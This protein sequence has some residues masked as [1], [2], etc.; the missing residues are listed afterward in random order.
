MQETF[1]ELLTY[2]VIYSF[3][4]WVLESVF[5]SIC[6]RK[7]INTG[8]LNGPF[9]PIYGVGAIIMIVFLKG[10]KENI[11]LLF[12]MA[13]FV[14]SVWEYVV[15]VFLEGVFHTK[16]WDYSEHKINLQGRVCL[17]NS[18]FWG[19]L[20]IV[21]I[22]YI[23]PFV[24][25]KLAF[26]NLVWLKVIIYAVFV[27]VLVDA[28]IS[29]VKI[30]NLKSTLEKI[31]ELNNQI[32]EKLEEIK[33]KSKEKGKVAFDEN[34]QQM[35]DKLNKERNRIIRKIYKRVSRLKKAFPTIDTKEITEILNKKIELKRK[36][37]K[38]SKVKNKHDK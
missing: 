14:L 28:V 5:R 25:G 23:H 27:V 29:I 36:E 21:F 37:F 16:Y 33:E 13:F 20:G 38:K 4:G 19:I 12:I 1:F 9:C 31:E 8:F 34:V 30:K 2:F 26:V 17:T 24:Q 6:E 15:G 10:F 18:I 7:I 22:R 3:A 11:F 35:V 32:K